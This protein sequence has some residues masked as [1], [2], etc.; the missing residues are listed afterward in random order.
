MWICRDCGRK[1]GT[2]Y[3]D[4]VCTWHIGDCGWCGKNK[5][6]TEDRDYGY[7]KPLT[8]K[9]KQN[10]KVNRRLKDP[11]GNPGP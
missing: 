6:V 9:Q 1:W 5:A 3:K 11:E 2:V 10:A 7:P 8:E 4:H